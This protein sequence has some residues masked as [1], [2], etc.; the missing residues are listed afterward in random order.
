[1]TSPSKS[2]IAQRYNL[3][4]SHSIARLEILVLLLIGAGLIGSIEQLWFIPTLLLCSLLAFLF[5]KRDSI[6][7]Q[8][9]AHTVIEFRT[10]PARLIWYDDFSEI[11]FNA[12]DIEVRLTRWFILLRLKGKTKT[13]HRVLLRDSFDSLGDYTRF[14]RQIIEMMH[15][16]G[17]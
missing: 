5:V 6:R 1:M 10:A 4:Y 7:N 15:V 3:R 17:N 8:F 14:R 13:L 16:S 11:S 2:A 9:N 12:H